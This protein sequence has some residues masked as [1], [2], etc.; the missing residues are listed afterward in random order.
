MTTALITH[1]ACLEHEQMPGHVE[2]PD[3]LRAVLK[4]LD[5]K[6]FAGL[7]REA[8]PRASANDVAAVH[9]RN[10]VE[11]IL[12][13]IPKPGGDVRYLL[14]GPDIM[15]SA[16]SGEAALRAA[17]A[18]MRGVDLVMSGEVRNAFCAVRPPGHHAGPDQPMGFCI[19]N[20]VAIGAM[21]A[22]KTHGL[23][24]I[25]VLDFDVHH[26]NG[27]Q[28]IFEHDRGL[29]F[30]SSHQSPLYPGTGSAREHG[31]YDNVLN[32]PLPPGSGSAA[33]REVM[34]SKALPALER[35]K[36]Q[37]L[38]ISAG[39]DAHERDSELGGLTGLDMCLTEDDFGWITREAMAVAERVCGG[40]VVSTLEGGYDLTGLALSAAAHVSALMA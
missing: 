16:G 8:A 10:L 4:A 12:A 30:I 9:D 35:F 26:G 1:L 21:H 2:S 13:A 11:A 14:V 3:R 18:V 37:L 29:M 33:F 31:D 25:A 5:S 40:R 38:L 15:A 28:D 32:L 36:P 6:K 19:F 17:G 34:V 27:T 39:F 23:E 24:R 7:R 20:N 22:R